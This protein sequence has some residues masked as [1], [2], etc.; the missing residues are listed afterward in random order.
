MS[1]DAD[2]KADIKKFNIYPNAGGKEVDVKGG[3]VELSYYEDIMSP[4]IRVSTGFIDTGFAADA[5]DGSGAKIT[6]SDKIKLTGMEKC[7]IELEDAFGQKIILKDIHIG[8]RQRL[9]EIFNDLEILEIVSKEN[10]RNESVRVV[11]RY[12]GKISDSIKKILQDVLQTTKPL[13]IEATKNER[14]YIGTTKKPFW[15]IYWLA[16]QSIRENTTASGLSAGYFFFETKSGFKFKSI[17]TLLGQK[18]TKK[19]IYNN[20]TSSQIPNGYTGKIINFDSNYTSDM[21]DK[22]MMGAFNSSVNLFNP[23]E[24]SFNCNP[25]NI[26]RQES[27]VTYPGTE[28]GKNLNSFFIKDSS[29]YFTGNEAIGGTFDVDRSHEIEIDKAKILSSSSSRYN[30]VFTNKVNITIAA[31]FSL[32]AGQTVFVDFPEQSSKTNTSNN[33]RMSGIYV[34]SALCHKVTPGKNSNGFQGITSLELV[35][36]SYGRKPI[37]TS[38]SNTG[39]TSAPSNSTVSG[40]KGITNAD[41]LQAASDERKLME[42]QAAAAQ[43]E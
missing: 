34:I 32:E 16:S 25:L 10:L 3:V 8:S 17:D 28:F 21:N 19:Y 36:D 2:S 20:T 15:F 6:A 33:P 26:E 35:R 13:D 41:A 18:P 22:L 43:A 30:Q 9:T 4:T 42:N 40:Q 23:F 12:D 5:G 38:S 11:K 14:S 1:L 31:D 7:E 24:S 39:T 37:N 27:G 29:R